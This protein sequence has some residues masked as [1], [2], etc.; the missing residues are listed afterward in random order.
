MS[1][2]VNANALFKDLHATG[3]I[4]PQSMNVLMANDLGQAIQ[5]ALGTPAFDVK[6]SS[7][8][9]L[10]MLLDDSGSIRMRGNS[11]ILR[12]GTNLVLTA[13]GKAKSRDAILVHMKTLNGILLCEYMPLAQAPRLDTHNYNPMGGTPL[14]DQTIAVLGT[15]LVKRKELR[16]AGISVRTVTLVVTD[17]HDEGSQGSMIDV[18]PVVEDMLSASEENILAAMGIDDG[19]TDFREVFRG[20]GFRDEWILTPANTEKE[21]RGAFQLFSSSA[22]TASQNAASFSKTASQG[23]GGGFA[24]P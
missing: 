1:N 10:T 17:G 11:Q 8:V 7:T 2:P 5:A 6:S 14:Y 18:K 16:D 22:R 19:K 13:V 20:M 12:D 24:A 23:L 15:V 4:S 9:L 21:I 3:D